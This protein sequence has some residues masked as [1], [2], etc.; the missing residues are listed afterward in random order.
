MGFGLRIF[1]IDKDNKIEKIPLSR[2]EK[3]RARDENEI[4]LEYKDSRIRYAE[5]VVELERRKPVSI[6]LDCLWLFTI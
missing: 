3:I 5:A 2:F 1:F 6:A 4:L